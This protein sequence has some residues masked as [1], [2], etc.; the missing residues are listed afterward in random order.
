MKIK[1][2]L[3]HADNPAIESSEVCIQL[4][5]KNSYFTAGI[6]TRSGGDLQRSQG[7]SYMVQI[8]KYVSRFFVLALLLIM[9]SCAGAKES[10]TDAPVKTLDLSEYSAD[11]PSRP[12]HLL[13]I[14]HSC[15]G[16]LFADKG[17]SSGEKCIYK[18]LP[19]GGGLRNLLQDKGYIVH[20]ASYGSV[21]GD[22]T[23][24]C[25]WN[26]KFRDQMDK[27][28]TCRHQDDFFKDGT[29]NSIIMFKSCF[30]NSWIEPDGD[31]TGD[32]DSC[33]H[34][35]E[36]YKA[37]YNSLLEYFRMQPDTLFVAVTAPPLVKPG[38]VR[39]YIKAVLGK[40]Q[41]FSV[42]EAGRRIRVFNDWLKDIEKGWLKGYELNNVVVFDLYDVLTDNGKSNW[43]LYPSGNGGDSHPNSEGN[44]KAAARFVPFL[45][46]AVHRAGLSD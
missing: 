35:L 45:N 12:L 39:Q 7:V 28:L 40:S 30:P 9:A 2:R 19:N 33:V 43:S 15:G 1:T 17:E 3:N 8:N 25:H 31:T 37:S 21:V 44:T 29:R 11:S 36:N 34:T 24:I 5:K 26:A 46:R 16:Q 22:K 38:R 32:P 20:E 18:S 41:E 27:V 10:N 23:D 13:F 14:H 6:F 42:D 4:I